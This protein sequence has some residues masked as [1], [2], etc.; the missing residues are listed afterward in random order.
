MADDK[1]SAGLTDQ[2]EMSN[3]P[4]AANPLTSMGIDPD[5]ARANPQLLAMLSRGG[6]NGSGASTPNIPSKP[7]PSAPVSMPTDDSDAT[8]MSALRTNL[9]TGSDTAKAIPTSN[10]EVERLSKEHE[11]LS[12]PAPLYDPQTGKMLEQDK[13]STG[14]KVWRGVRGGLVG[15][16]TGGIPGA[17]IGAIEPQ[18]IAGGKAYNAPNVQYTRGE[19]RREQELGATDSNLANARENWKSVVD[20]AKAKGAITKDVAGT[21]ADM[22]T[23]SSRLQ[24]AATKQFMAEATADNY[25]A[26]AEEADN[27]LQEQMKEKLRT[28]QDNEQ[29]L[30]IMRD[31]AMMRDQIQR[32][33]LDFSKQKLS[34][35][36]DAKTIDQWQKEQID[37]VNKDYTGVLNS[38]W[39]RITAGSKQDRIADINRTADSRR[40]ALGLGT[41][42]TSPVASA[43]AAPQGAT[44]IAP[45]SDGKKHYTNAQGKDFGVAP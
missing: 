9:Q 28:A 29:R 13:P 5:M 34:T 37:S 8:A 44:H 4:S 24:A 27:K 38:A 36:T 30:A 2:D 16:L 12:L 35:V 18:D 1:F 10:P 45:G 25:K 39:N 20:A 14:Q 11:R 22:L 6:G 33:Q 19:Q 15:L 17:A 26:K 41:G 31:T 32:A 3:F 21:A 23:G 43:N 42:T 40:A 7:S